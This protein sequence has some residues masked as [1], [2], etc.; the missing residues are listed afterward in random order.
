MSGLI[1]IGLYI[2]DNKELFDKLYNKKNEIEKELGFSLD[3]RRL[4]NSKASR[5]VYDINGLNFEDHSNYNELM[6]KIIDLAIVLRK[7]FKKYI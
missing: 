2:P 3:W 6:N 4:D 5:I 7:V 1:V